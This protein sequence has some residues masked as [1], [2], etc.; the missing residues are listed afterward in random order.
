[1]GRAE[2]DGVGIEY[3][4]T[5]AGRPVVLLHGFPDSGRLWRHQVPALAGAGFQV[6]VPDLRGYGRSG[7][8]EAIEAYSL[9]LLAGDVMAVLTDLDITKAH[10]VGHDWGAALGWAL[11]SLAP[12]TVDHLAALSVGSPVT[13]RRTL[14]QREK[15]WYMLLFQFPGIAER[16]LTENNWANFRNWAHHPDTDQVIAELEAD[17]SLTP[18]LNWYRANVPPE[19]WVGPPVQL[20]PVQAPTMGVWSTGDPAL[21]EAQMTDSAA[22]MAGPWRY[23]RL[24]GP[25]HWMQLEA[26]DQVNALLLDFL[27]R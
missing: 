15:S 16:W 9:P 11:A 1:M 5:G 8:P 7:K 21:T 18:G 3:E 27:P 14:E 17:G 10:L 4:V 26:P 23:E 25:G 20:P 22:T 6:I 2:V 12:A 24:G 13:F 19:S